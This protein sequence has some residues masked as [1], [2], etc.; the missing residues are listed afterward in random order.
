M[1]LNFIAS[2]TGKKYVVYWENANV[3]S[4]MTDDTIAV[5]NADFIPNYK[6]RW[7]N[8]H[9]VEYDRDNGEL[10][11]TEHTEEMIENLFEIYRSYGHECK[12]IDCVES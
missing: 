2:D 12:V 10:T 1:I 11:I 7:G 9:K 8:P 5:M 3:L 4:C 6:C